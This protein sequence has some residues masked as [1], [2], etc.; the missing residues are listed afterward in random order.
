MLKEFE[1]EFLFTD[2]G[3]FSNGKYGQLYVHAVKRNITKGVYAIYAYAGACTKKERKYQLIA[4]AANDDSVIR[5]FDNKTLRKMFT[6]QER[7]VLRET[8]GGKF[9]KFEQVLHDFSLALNV[10]EESDSRY[11]LPGSVENKEEYC[12]ATDMVEYALMPEEFSVEER[13]QSAIEDMGEISCM[14]GYFW[15]FAED[16]GWFREVTLRWLASVIAPEYPRYDMQ[17]EKNLYITQLTHMA[18]DAKADAS[19]P[20]SKYIGMKNAVKGH[21]LVTVDFLCANDSIESLKVHARAFEDGWVQTMIGEPIVDFE[22]YYAGEPAALKA[23]IPKLT[24]TSFA[25]LGAEGQ[26]IGRN[27]VLAIRDGEQVLWSASIQEKT[28]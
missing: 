17:R 28:A 13:L 9:I 2:E 24:S 3:E 11:P 18:E 4:V 1:K 14:N 7:N 21:D 23:I 27:N 5:F 19:N 8:F 6:A 12:Y 16:E 26:W 22:E 20:L 25:D 10:K 15:I